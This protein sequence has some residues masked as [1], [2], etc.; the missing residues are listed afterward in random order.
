MNKL[1]YALIAVPIV[2]G[3]SSSLFYPMK[4]SS[5]SA[6]FTP[7]GWV[8]APM[9]AILFLLLGVAWAICAASKNER[10]VHLKF[11]CITVLLTLYPIVRSKSKKSAL[12]LVWLSILAVSITI[13]SVQ[14]NVARI[15]LTFLLIWLFFASSLGEEEDA[16][17]CNI[18]K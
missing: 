16:A 14:S 4:T 12:Y 8:F 17:Q 3:F 11:A 7:P 18:C 10:M 6:W 1:N 13:I 15:C 9:W 2:A 5:A